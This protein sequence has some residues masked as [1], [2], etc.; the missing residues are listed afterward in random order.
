MHLRVGGMD[1][2]AGFRVG[3]VQCRVAR[4]RA[5]VPVLEDAPGR[6]DERILIVWL[7]HHRDIIQW[8]EFCRSAVGRNSLK[9]VGVP[10]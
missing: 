9:R 1:I 2:D 10:G 8:D 5:A 7:F 4:H 6:E 3:F